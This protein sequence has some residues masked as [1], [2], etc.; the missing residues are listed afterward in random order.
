MVAA[1]FK[2]GPLRFP[3]RTAAFAVGNLDG[4]APSLM[5]SLIAK[6]RAGQFESTSQMLSS[7]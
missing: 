7:S 2:D 6:L 5:T 3:E 1:D 4:I